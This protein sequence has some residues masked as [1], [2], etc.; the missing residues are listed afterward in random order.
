MIWNLPMP[1]APLPANEAARLQALSSY[2]VLDSACEASF[3]N[4]ARL[5]CRLTGSPIGLVSLVD[6][7][8]Q[9]FKARHGL[10]ASE[11]SR[12]VAFCAYALLDPE[13]PLVVPDATQDSRFADN[14]LVTGQLGIRF[15]LGVPLVNP[16]GFALGTLCIIDQRP[17]EVGPEMLDILKG[18]AQ[19]V[20]TTLE[21][22]RAMLRV[23]S[24]AM[25]DALT[26]LPNRPAFLQALGQAISRQAR[27][28]DPFSL[29]YVDLDR[30][31]RINDTYGHA[32]GD[33]VL[34]EAADALRTSLRQEDTPA[35]LGGD[36]F[37]AV[38]VGG[39]GSE[40]VGAAERV[41]AAIEARLGA[42]GWDVTASVGS[43]AFLTPVAGVDEAI[44]AADQLMYRAKSLGRNRVVGFDHTAVP[45]AAVRSEAPSAVGN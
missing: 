23:Q 14:A 40:A 5:A 3:D 19:A 18:L 10:D 32:T 37:G 16:E 11:T 17:R 20:T 22:R 29:L 42:G 30:F 43:V 4:I 31:K 24:I 34:A 6:A 1:P 25:T 8:R 39:D 41:R 12:D 9:W 38:L 28:G 7:D 21:L 36:E 45:E 2:E 15:Y 27:N 33:R 44:A 26:G 13:N 35:R